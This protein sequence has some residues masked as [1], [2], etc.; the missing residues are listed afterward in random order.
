MKPRCPKLEY[1]RQ[2]KEFYDFY[3]KERIP[4][5]IFDF[6]IHINLPEHIPDMT[7]ETIRPPVVS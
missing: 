4:E 1:T 2:D 3:L 5:E 7:E 6:H